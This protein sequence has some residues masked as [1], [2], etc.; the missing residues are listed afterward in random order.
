MAPSGRRLRF[1]VRVD[2]A[3][4]NG[5]LVDLVLFLALAHVTCL[6]RTLLGR[7]RR[8]RDAAVGSDRLGSLLDH[9]RV[10]RRVVRQTLI[11][12]HLGTVAGRNFGHHGHGRGR[13]LF[14]VA[15]RT[16]Y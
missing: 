15:V 11:D 12:R 5:H 6:R 13:D 16:W 2:E 9:A 1:G 3:A 10:E 4:G 8:Q 7:L 14:L